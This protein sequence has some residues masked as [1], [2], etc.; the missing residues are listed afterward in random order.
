MPRAASAPPLP[1]HARETAEAAGA[2]LVRQDVQ[3]VDP[4]GK[5]AQ[6]AALVVWDAQQH[7]MDPY[8]SAMVLAG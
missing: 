1:L 3:A 7:T 8:P 5:A 6:A 4:E 2:G